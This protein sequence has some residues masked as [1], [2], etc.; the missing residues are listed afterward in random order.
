MLWML[1]FRLEQ[2]R[3]RISDFSLLKFSCLVFVGFSCEQFQF[4]TTV[5]FGR[6]VTSVVLVFQLVGLH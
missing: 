4:E 3:L 5:G 1:I 2:V 6:V